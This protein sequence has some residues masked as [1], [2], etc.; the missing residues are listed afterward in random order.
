MDSFFK[1]GFVRDNVKIV[2]GDL[3]EVPSGIGCYII[4]QCCC[5]C[6]KTAGLSAAIAAKWSALNPYK[7]RK[8]IGRTHT[9]TADTRDEPGTALLLTSGGVNLISLF[10]QYS[11]GKSKNYTDGDVTVNDTALARRSY[12]QKSLLAM[13]EI[14]GGESGDDSGVAL[15]LYF[16]Y[17]IG[18][19]LAG[20][21]W[22]LYEKMIRDFGKENPQYNIVIV[23][24]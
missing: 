19:G 10:A 2:D 15:T 3:L 14:I 12:F 21:K 18:C 11:P 20:G 17:G 24:K 7:S 8:A 16:P 23:K 4:Q 1:R 13:K 5:I 9:A 6:T 22:E